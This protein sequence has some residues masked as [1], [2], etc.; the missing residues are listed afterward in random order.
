M[1]SYDQSRKILKKAK[2]KIKDETIPSENSLNR[3]ISNNI[4]SKIN[5]PAGDNAAFDGFAVNSKDTNGIKKNSPKQFKIIGSIAA[6]T[7][8]LNKKIKKY[9]AV[10]IMT[11]GII[12]PVII[13]AVSNFFIF[14]LNG[15]IPAAIEPIILNFFGNFF[16]NH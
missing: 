10:E 8:S 12:P 6:G 2:I 3:V 15:F 1:I 14:F 5:Y 13:S 9:D 11:G 16:L 4:Y 7:K